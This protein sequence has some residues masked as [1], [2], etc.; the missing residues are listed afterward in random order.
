MRPQH[1]YFEIYLKLQLLF[2]GSV[3][4]CGNAIF[5]GNEQATFLPRY[6]L[7][8][9]LPEIGDQGD[10][11]SCVGWAS[12]YYGLTV[13]K[14]IEHGQNYPVF[15]ALSTYNRYCFFY[16]KNPCYGGS[17]I[18]GSL[19]VLKKYGSPYMKDYLLQN[20]AHDPDKNIYSDR[21]YD[22]ERLQHMNY[23]QIKAAI[24]SNRPVVIGMNVYAGGKGN[25][26]N[27]KF[28]D[29]N[30]VIKIE[31][32]NSDFAVA[33]HAMCIIGYDD[34][35]GGGAFKLV[36]SW[37]KEWGKNGFCWLRYKD[38]EILRAAFSLIPNEFPKLS[39]SSVFKTQSME[40]LNTSAKNYYVS[41]GIS[42][43]DGTQE[44]RGWYYIPSGET[45]VINIAN[46]NTNEVYYLL[47]DDMG[48]VFESKTKSIN[49]PTDRDKFFDSKQNKD[50][51]GLLDFSYYSLLPSNKKKTQQ[52]FITGSTIPKISD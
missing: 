25:S 9:Y 45:R 38:L 3:I 7:E 51:K 46:R 19:E 27:T 41:Y 12:T 16:D 15:S 44:A 5:A 23:L 20:C 30:G 22:Y 1:Q 48:Q 34:Q 11:G 4:M 8:A 33:G 47:M 13:I 24:T 21:L 2:F 32:F 29:S 37:G 17:Q 10:V 43:V 18:D 26:L 14:R 50:G 35:I 31:N 28:L 36:N 39:K 52:L 42:N 40:L 6:S 49:I